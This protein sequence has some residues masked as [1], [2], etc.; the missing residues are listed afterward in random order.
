MP[1]KELPAFRP[2]KLESG[3]PLKRASRHED[4]AKVHR[5]RRA[6]KDARREAKAAKKAARRA[7]E[8][9]EIAAKAV[10]DMSLQ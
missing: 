5:A 3:G 8:A 2:H 1:T 10:E 4:M 6:I 7:R 9:E